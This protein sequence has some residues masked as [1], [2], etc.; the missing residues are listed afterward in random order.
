[1]KEMKRAEANHQHRG[2]NSVLY[3]K[4]TIAQFLLA[5]SSRSSHCTCLPRKEGEEEEK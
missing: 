2:A 3:S 4:E 1:M 5:T